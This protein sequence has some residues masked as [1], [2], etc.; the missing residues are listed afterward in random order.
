[1]PKPDD[2][3]T[4]RLNASFF[5]RDVLEV[6]PELLGKYLVR[7]YDDGHIAR[8]RITEI[9]A[10]RGI[11]DG[12]CHASKG[13]TKRNA[14]MFE[15]GGKI[16]MYLI[17]GMYHMLNFV[18]GEKDDPQAILIRGVEG[19][20]GPGKLTRDLHISRDFY[21]EDLTSSEKIWVEDNNPVLSFTQHPRVGIQYATPYWRDIPWRF[22]VKDF[23]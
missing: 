17:Y 23:A 2:N 6:C 8:F 16:Y 10:Y 4:K 5:Q 3:K 19:I 12:A 15:H 9:E 22:I 1:M 18:T 13:K 20:N 21:D 7:K 11:D 14:V